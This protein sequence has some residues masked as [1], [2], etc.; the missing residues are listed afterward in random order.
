MEEVRH[1][2]RDCRCTGCWSPPGSPRVPAPLHS[3]DHRWRAPSCILEL[4][5]SLSLPISWCNVPLSRCTVANVGGLRGIE[6]SGILRDPGQFNVT[7]PFMDA[8]D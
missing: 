7:T 4:K 3:A 1:H 8:R 6:D 5:G 2:H